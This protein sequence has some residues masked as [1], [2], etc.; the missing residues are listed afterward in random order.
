[1]CMV[2]PW[3]ERF[4]RPTVHS[5]VY[6][7]RAPD[8]PALPSG[9]D[10]FCFYPSPRGSTFSPGSCG[11]EGSFSNLLRHV[12][13]FCPS[14]RGPAY[15]DQ[16]LLH[17]R[18]VSGEAAGFCAYSPAAITSQACTTSEGR[19]GSLWSSVLPIFSCEHLAE[20]H[21]KGLQVRTP[22]VFGAPSYSKLIC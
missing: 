20:A 22:L 17:M 6:L 21:K 5:A 2:V 18:D 13:C 9:E 15:S 12:F 11:R 19:E 3:Q 14:P 7:F 8:F 10:S 16:V 1:M 4:F